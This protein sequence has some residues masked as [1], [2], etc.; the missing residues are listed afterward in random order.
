VTIPFYDRILDSIEAYFA[1][2]PTMLALSMTSTGPASDEPPAR[3]SVKA[4]REA[5]GNQV[6]AA[7]ERDAIWSQLVQLAQVRKEPWDLAAV[8]MMI[9]GMRKACGRCRRYAIGID[10]AELQAEAVAGFLEALHNADPHRQELES[11]L[12]WTTYRHL[13]RVCSRQRVETPTAEIELMADRR[14]WRRDAADSPSPRLSRLNRAIV[15]DPDAITRTA[16]ESERLGSLAHRMGLRSA[17]PQ[18]TT[19]NPSEQAA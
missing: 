17:L 3:V 1:L 11:W 6:V 14:S 9:P 7:G 10:L 5:L 8:W 15:R 12:W 4:V 2:S 13:Q 16:V 18:T 19:P